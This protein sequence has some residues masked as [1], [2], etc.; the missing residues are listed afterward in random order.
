MG[1]DGLEGARAVKAAGGVILVEAE[2]TCTVYGMPRA[3][4]EAGLADEVVPLD[5]LPEAIAREAGA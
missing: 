1:K 2:E 5:Q 4:E 3:I